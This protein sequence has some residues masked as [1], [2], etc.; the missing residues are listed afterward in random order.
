MVTWKDSPGQSLVREMETFH[1]RLRMAEIVSG[2][3]TVKHRKETKT[4]RFVASKGFFNGLAAMYERWV[5]NQKARE[6][7]SLDTDPLL[8]SL[9]PMDEHQLPKE[10]VDF[11]M[12]H[13]AALNVSRTLSQLS[14]EATGRLLRLAEHHPVGKGCVTVANVQN[15]V[16]VYYGE[17]VLKI[18]GDSY[19][20]LKRLW[21]RHAQKGAVLND[22]VFCI[23]QRYETLS[24]ASPGNQMALPDHAFDVLRTQ[25]GVSHECFASPL[26]CR[27]PSFC[28]MFPDTDTCFGSKGS[29]FDFIPKE[30]SYEA[31]PPFLETIL[32]DTVRHIINL[33]TASTAPL[34]F[35]LVAPGWDDSEFYASATSSPFLTGRLSLQSHNHFYKNGMQHRLPRRNR[36]RKSEFPSFVFFLQNDAGASRWPVTSTKL[37]LLRKAFAYT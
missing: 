15:I 19:E 16:N 18:A 20:K 33:L 28:S 13:E 14:R 1:L 3:A 8:P 9:A 31:N 10:L 11:G 27:L 2:T 26:N 30:G 17:K 6:G 23:L 5:I 4:S 7:Q 24:G 22:D 34:S 37:N 21:K 35:V 32:A 29:F 25:L 36:Y 12:T